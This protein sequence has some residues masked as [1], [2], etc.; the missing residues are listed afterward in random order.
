MSETQVLMT[1]SNFW[2][3]LSRNHFLEGGF[4]FQYGGLHFKSVCVCVCMCVCVC[5]CVCEGGEGRGC[6]KL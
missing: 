3:F 1:V 4:I 6:K 5:V 2:V